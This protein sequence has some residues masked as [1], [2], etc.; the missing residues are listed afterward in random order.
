M[1]CMALTEWTKMNELIPRD[2]YALV[3]SLGYWPVSWVKLLPN[4]HSVVA[5]K[6]ELPYNIQIEGKQE[7]TAFVW[8]VDTIHYLKYRWNNTGSKIL[9]VL[10][11]K[12]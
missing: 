1:R 10:R 4:R 11:I 2:I 6:D 5:I 3:E 9:H 8:K 7:G 12:V